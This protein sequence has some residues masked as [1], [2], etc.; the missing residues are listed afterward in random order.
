MHDLVHLRLD[1]GD[2]TPHFLAAAASSIARAAAPH[3][4]MGWMKWRTLRE[5]SVSWLP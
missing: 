4:R 5:P 3:W 2:G 1:L